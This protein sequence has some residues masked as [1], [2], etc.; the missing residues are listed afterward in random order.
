M[1][2]LEHQP[3]YPQCQRFRK[4]VFKE[5]GRYRSTNTI[6]ILLSLISPRVVLSQ[7]AQRYVGLLIFVKIGFVSITTPTPNTSR[8]FPASFHQP[9][10][11][12]LR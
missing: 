5:T 11:D 1:R 4:V 8:I 2:I 9:N 3:W 7:I 10:G 12:I 6:I